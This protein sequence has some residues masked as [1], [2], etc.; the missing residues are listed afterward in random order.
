MSNEAEPESPPTERQP[1]DVKSSIDWGFAQNILILLQE[2]ITQSMGKL[3]K[4]NSEPYLTRFKDLFHKDPMGYWT[5]VDQLHDIF[6]RFKEPALEHPLRELIMGVEPIPIA[7]SAQ[8]YEEEFVRMLLVKLWPKAQGAIIVYPETEHERIISGAIGAVY[9]WANAETVIRQIECNTNTLTTRRISF[10]VKHMHD[11]HEIYSSDPLGFWSILDQIQDR[12]MGADWDG[13]RNNARFIQSFIKSFEPV[14]YLLTPYMSS[15]IPRHPLVPYRYPPHILRIPG[16]FASIDR[17]V[18]PSAP[19][20]VCATQD[21]KIP[22]QQ[23]R[24]AHSSPPPPDS[25][26]SS[27]PDIKTLT[28]GCHSFSPTIS[29]HHHHH[30]HGNINSNKSH[31]PNVDCETPGGLPPQYSW[32]NAQHII[33]EIAASVKTATVVFDEKHTHDLRVRW[34]KDPMAFFSIL[35]QIHE[36]FMQTNWDAVRD[37][38]RYIQ[39]HINKTTPQSSLSPFILSFLC[40]PF[41]SSSPSSSSPSVTTSSSSSH[42][43][44]LPFGALCDNSAP[45]TNDT[46]SGSQ[47]VNVEPQNNSEMRCG[48]NGESTADTNTSSI[49]EGPILWDNVVDFILPHIEMS[50]TQSVGTLIKFSEMHKSDLKQLLEIKRGGFWWILDQIHEKLKSSKWSCVTDDAH[51]IQNCIRDVATRKYGVVD[52]GSSTL[53]SF[54]SSL[55]SVVDNECTDKLSPFMQELIAAM[56]EKAT[57]AHQ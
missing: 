18:Y 54:S 46:G 45:N 32:S 27:S 8:I 26:G 25:P 44:S 12:M 41:S 36:K 1:G 16:A 30:H 11:L 21:K 40:S 37:I 7:E 42:D 38:A 6:T 35:D 52:S 33:N 2:K 24:S 56:H 47:C 43:I 28:P 10:D 23:S 19:P 3:I 9:T 15:I 39:W 49:N 20:D 53:S 13:V 34:E 48:A 5:V 22:R 55:S 29:R 31:Y 17:K 57:N 14:D 50:L 51:F 4:L